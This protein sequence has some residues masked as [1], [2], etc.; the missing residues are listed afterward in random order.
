MDETGSLILLICKGIDVMD[1]QTL[2]HCRI[3]IRKQVKQTDTP[4]PKWYETQLSG[5]HRL[6]SERIKRS[7]VQGWVLKRQII[8]G[9]KLGNPY[10]FLGRGSDFA[11]M[12]DGQDGRGGTRKRKP[13]C[14]GR[15]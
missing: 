7:P 12:N 9:M 11:R 15:G 1:K 3:V 8:S 2:N 6:D 14:N 5:I 10:W 13:V 4:E